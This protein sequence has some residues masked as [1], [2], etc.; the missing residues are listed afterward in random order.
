[1]YTNKVEPT[2]EQPVL[3]RRALTF[4]HDN[5][6]RDITL[7]DIAASVNVTPRSVQYTFRRHIGSTPLEYLRSLRLSHAHRELQ[8]AD[9]SVD[10]VMAI[11]GRWGFG[12]A[13]RFSSMYK[14]T[15]GH[16][17]SRTLRG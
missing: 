4:I 3:L 7:S 12:H 15:F 6:H 9:P 8:A 2:A 16:S 10:T 1:M 11:A 13:G 14:Q 5:A 17:P